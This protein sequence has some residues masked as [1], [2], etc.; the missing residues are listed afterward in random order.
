[1]QIAER[2]GHRS[3]RRQRDADDR[4][5]GSPRDRRGELARVRNLCHACD[6]SHAPRKRDGEYNLPGWV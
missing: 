4:Q 3:D 6:P 5:P 2:R 1:M